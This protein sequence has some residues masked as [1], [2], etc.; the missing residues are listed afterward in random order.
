M[1]I[2]RVS[3]RRSHAVESVIPGDDIVLRLWRQDDRAALELIFE[4]SRE[5]L[6]DWLPGA[7]KDLADL[8]V[9]LD[10]VESASGDGTGY[11]Y[12][13]EEDGEAVG[14]C[15]LH[16]RAVGIAEIGY[17]VRTDR[18]G[19]GLASRAVNSL[20][21]AAFDDGLCELVIH[22]DEA[23]VRSA[24]VAANAG[25]VHVETVQLDPALRRT[26][27]QSGREMTWVRRRG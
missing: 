25:F 20:A 17:W 4:R 19:R 26:R 6:A 12:A 22:C 7:T 5:D 10:H 16:H 8:D 24:K 23:N 14:Q 15:S 18:S 3:R 21:A 1:A 2:D 9:F 13:I 11:F 27:A